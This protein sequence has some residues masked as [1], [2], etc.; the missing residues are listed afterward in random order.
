[1][2]FLN[3][4]TVDNKIK[5]IVINVNELSLSALIR[6]IRKIPGTE[7]NSVSVNQMNDDCNIKIKYKDINIFLYTPF[8]DYILECDNSGDIFD[9]FV[10]KLSLY[11]VRW[12]E[13]FF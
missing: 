5:S 11:K 6:C 9:E 4:E 1:M 10:K 2:D 7:I 12:W 8:S 3:K 13:R